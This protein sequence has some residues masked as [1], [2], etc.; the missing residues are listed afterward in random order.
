MNNKTGILTINAGSSSIKFSVY[1]VNPSL[2]KTLYGQIQN[3]GSGNARF[4]S[5]M[6]D[7][8][9]QGEF[10]DMDKAGQWLIEW[11]EKQNIF[12]RIA[13]IG[14]RIVHGLKHTAP[15]IITTTLLEELNSISAYDPEHLPG[16]IR[17][18]ES[19]AQHNPDLLQV[20]CFDTSFHSSMPIVAQFL[21]IPRSF[22]DKGIRRYGFHGLSYTYL[23]EE[24][25][26]QAGDEA[27]KGKVIL[28]H[29]GSGASMAAVKEGKS[30]D[31]S[32]GFTPASGLTMSTRAGD[33]D[34]GVAWYLMAI[35][36]FSPEAFN[37]L[38]NH[39][40]GLLGISETSSDMHDLLLA[41]AK[42]HRAAEAVDIFCYLAKKYV[43]SYAAALN[44]LDTLI[45]SGGIGENSPEVRSAICEGLEFLGIEIDEVKNRA[46][47][48]VISTD[49]S[50]VAIR[51]IKTN[52]ELIIA[53]LVGKL[54][55]SKPDR[56]KS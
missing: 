23:M 50:R 10:Q 41:R 20:A 17:L 12:S 15:E 42:D 54:V 1:D 52:E 4:T 18:V 56:W 5:S 8:H 2:N 14:H 40:S 26:S 51:V 3:I 32:M 48:Q 55:N 46:N 25:G 11:L 34:P 30:I 7:Q 44:G 19:L 28:A 45:F 6:S 33:L 27:M 13:A 47:E 31:T 9:Y 29:L 22:H 21:T 16:E 49:N 35:E 37:D 53:R 24:L 36:K 39:K 38:I 43:G